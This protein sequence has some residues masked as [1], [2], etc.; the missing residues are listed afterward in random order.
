MQHNSLLNVSFTKNKTIVKENWPKRVEESLSLL[1][2]F[3][4]KMRK[5]ITK[6]GSNPIQK[7]NS[8]FELPNDINQNELYG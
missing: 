4:G 8:D 1:K 7:I 6:S 2:I 5:K 3:W